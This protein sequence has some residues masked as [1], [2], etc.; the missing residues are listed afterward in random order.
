MHVLLIIAIPRP[1]LYMLG[2]FRAGMTLLKIH[3]RHLNVAVAVLAIGLTGCD[4]DTFRGAAAP[5]AE[6]IAADNASAERSSTASYLVARQALAE[7]NVPLAADEFAAIQTDNSTNINLLKFAFSTFYL[8]G[9]VENAALMASQI[10]KMGELVAFGSEPALILAFEAGDYLGM[11]VLADYLYEDE[12][13][14]PIGIVAGAWSL[15]LQN[16]GDAG[17]TRLLDLRGDI[18]GGLPYALF[19]QRALMNE[20]LG[21]SADAVSSARKAV[22]H[23]EVSIDTIIIM[24]GV[25][26]R[27]N[28]SDEAH[29]ILDKSLDQFFDKKKILRDIRSGRSALYTKP[30]IN[31]LLA[32]AIIEASSVRY[33]PRVFSRARVLLSVRLSKDNHRVN[34]VMGRIYQSFNQFDQAMLYYDKIDHG[35][36]WYQPTLYHKALYMSFDGQDQEKAKVIFDDLVRTNPNS[37]IIWQEYGD[38]ARRR[39]D[40]QGALDAYEKAA[41]LNS[42]NPRLYFL[43][44]VVLD[45]LGQKEKTESTLRQSIAL[46]DEDADVL[47]YLGYWLLEEGGDPEEALSFIRKAIEKQPQNGAFMD[48]LGWGHYRLGQY[49]QAVLYLERAVMLEPQDPVITDHLGDAYAKRGRVR[50]ARY[51]WERALNFGPDDAL[52]LQI[53]SKLDDWVVE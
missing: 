45:R 33:D 1:I 20:Y 30:D 51:Q 12:A 27:Q 34:Y 16:R 5:E 40:Y 35:S 13:T 31:D 8:D 53:L 11:L 7:D 21:R 3:W 43:K 52:K 19:S 26:A 28:F 47:N 50:E 10:E 41:S 23:P 24:A 14:R 46:N 36:L 39:D 25:L 2:H 29:D 6:I 44:A 37:H 17:L 32:E 15:I 49:Q 9:D 42:K 4:A 22:N 48:S 38:A 18:D